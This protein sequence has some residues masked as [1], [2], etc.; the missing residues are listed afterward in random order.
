MGWTAKPSTVPDGC[1]AAATRAQISR[2]AS[3]AEAA[4]AMLSTTPTMSDLR[5]IERDRRLTTIA[6]WVPIA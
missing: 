6:G 1:P 2:A 4:V 3:R 5:V